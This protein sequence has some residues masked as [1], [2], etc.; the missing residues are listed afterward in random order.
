MSAE[1]FGL[2]LNFV[3]SMDVG[4]I[5]PKPIP[6]KSIPGRARTSSGIAS[7]RLLGDK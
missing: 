2:N 4:N 5:G 6:I 1:Y 7:K 3:E